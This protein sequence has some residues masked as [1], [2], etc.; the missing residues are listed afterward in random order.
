V[1]GVGGSGVVG[2]VREG[3]EVGGTVALREGRDGRKMSK[4]NNNVIGV[5]E[6]PF[7]MSGKVMSLADELIPRY[8]EL[9]TDVPEKEIDQMRREIA[10]GAVNPMQLKKRLA[11]DLVSQFHDAEAA[12]Q[13]QE[14]FEREI[15]H[16]ELPAE[17]PEVA[18][19]RDG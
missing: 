8:F 17:I 16:R 3:E 4:S 2:A 15:Q 11:F 10:S 5:A 7:E 12:R 18:L 9:L 1:R 14:R 13:A 6:P 19:P